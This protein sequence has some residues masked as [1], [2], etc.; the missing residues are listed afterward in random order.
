MNLIL[1][2]MLRGSSRLKRSG[3]YLST[4]RKVGWRIVMILILMILM[5]AILQEKV[6][7]KKSLLRGIL[8]MM[9]LMIMKMSPTIKFGKGSNIQK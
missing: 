1:I 9:I 8:R 4:A 7:R 5:T 3:R 2:V 6:I